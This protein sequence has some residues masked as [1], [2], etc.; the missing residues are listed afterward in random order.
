VNQLEAFRDTIRLA[1]MAGMPEGHGS[2]IGLAHLQEMLAAAQSESFSEAK[3]G[4][5]LGWAQCAVVAANV[6]LTLADMKSVNTKWSTEHSS[7]RVSE[8]TASEPPD[9]DTLDEYPW[10]VWSVNLLDPGRH[11][12][13][14]VAART[15]AVATAA[16][17][18]YG[19]VYEYCVDEDTMPDGTKYY[20]WLIGVSQAEHRRRVGNAPVV[21]AE[22]VGRLLTVLPPEIDIDDHWTLGPD[23][24]A[25]RIRNDVDHGYPG[26]Q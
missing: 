21:V 9:I 2:D 20:S 12:G 16:A 4:R 24:H 17:E 18:L 22:M 10:V 13:D 3:L 14:D 8:Q 19:C 11:A 26:R 1:E 23:L 25:T 5:W 15:A 7:P 6:G